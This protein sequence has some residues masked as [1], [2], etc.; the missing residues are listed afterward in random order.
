MSMAQN[1]KDEREAVSICFVFL[2][3]NVSMHVS[4]GAHRLH[5]YHIKKNTKIILKK[6]IASILRRPPVV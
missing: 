4:M 2:L 3:A 6:Y 1:K 5:T